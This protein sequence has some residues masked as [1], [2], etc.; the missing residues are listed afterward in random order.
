[1]ELKEVIELIIKEIERNSYIIISDF[2]KENHLTNLKIK[3]L[4]E[5]IEKKYNKELILDLKNTEIYSYSL[6]YNYFKLKIFKFLE[7]GSDNDIDL[8]SDDFKEFKSQDLVRIFSIIDSEF[9][10]YLS[11]HI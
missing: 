2:L 8:S 5:E 3:D 4:V 9:F 1:M 6:V 7:S 11:D 10:N